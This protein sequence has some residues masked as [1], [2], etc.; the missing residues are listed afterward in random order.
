MQRLEL[1]K[2]GQNF[3]FLAA[4]NPITLLIWMSSLEAFKIR[5]SHVFQTGLELV[6]QSSLTF[7][8]HIFV[9]TYF[10]SSAGMHPPLM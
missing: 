1:L 6:V 7:E 9:P 8:L 3:P 5:E 10:L 2:V 4:V